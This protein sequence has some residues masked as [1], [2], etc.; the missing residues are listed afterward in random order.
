[1]EIIILDGKCMGDFESAHDYLGR[2]LRLPEYY[3]RNLDALYDCLCGL[4][5]SD[6]IIIL[7][8]GGQMKN[9]LG[10][11]G[12]K[13]IQVFEDAMGENGFSFIYKS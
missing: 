3:G 2:T 7:L 12:D 11:Y 5:T 8:N 9:G 1:M 6:C 13:L 4:F 10:V